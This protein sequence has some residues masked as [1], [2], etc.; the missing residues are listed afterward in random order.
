MLKAGEEGRPV[1]LGS[2]SFDRGVGLSRYTGQVTHHIAPDLDEERDTLIADLVRAHMVEAVYQVTGIGPTLTGRNGGGDLYRTDGEVK[3]A[4]LVPD[5]IERAATPEI[6]D[7]PPL[8][9]LK[10]RAFDV[11][12]NLLD[13]DDQGK[14]AAAPGKP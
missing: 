6:F 5:G 12:D 3:I 7:A 2:A 11:I 8:V 10:D 9:K 13:D 14:E 4:R 1:W